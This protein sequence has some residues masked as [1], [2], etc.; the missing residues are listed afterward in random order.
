M[1]YPALMFWTSPPKQL[2]KVLV[3]GS[4]FFVRITCAVVGGDTGGGLVC[5]NEVVGSKLFGPITM[6]AD[7][8][9]T[10]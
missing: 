1:L 10:M 8:F 9:T 4:W 3:L 5:R 2:N 7:L 6:S